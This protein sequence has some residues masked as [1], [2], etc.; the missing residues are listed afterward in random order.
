MKFFSVKLYINSLVANSGQP[1]IQ[2]EK[3]QILPIKTAG[4]RKVSRK[5]TSGENPVGTLMTV[6]IYIFHV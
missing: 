5:S 6:Y 1:E 3:L 4:K 2:Q